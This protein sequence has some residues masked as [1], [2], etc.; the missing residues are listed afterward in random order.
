MIVPY[1]L[2]ALMPRRGIRA[3]KAFR[4]KGAKGA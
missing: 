4:G 1:A 3:F 2:N